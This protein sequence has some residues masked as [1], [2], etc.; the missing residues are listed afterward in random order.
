MLQ[1]DTFLRWHR[2]A[3]VWHWNSKSRRL[4]GRPEGAAN[5][6]DLIQRMS[7]ANPLRRAPR[8]QRE[9]PKLGLRG[10]IHCGQIFA[11]AAQTAVP[12]S[13]IMHAP[14]QTDLQPRLL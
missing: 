14:D 5:I 11:A 2:I 10:A 7:Q 4:P 1:P 3:L 8:I 13:K 6:R 9:L 12:G